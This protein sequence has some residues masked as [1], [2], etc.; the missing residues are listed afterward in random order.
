MCSYLDQVGSTDYFRRTVPKDLVGT[1]LTNSGRARTEW[2]DSLATKDRETA[3]R[4]L[5][6]HEIDTDALID[7]ARADAKSS[8]RSFPIGEAAQARGLELEAA[9]LELAEE[10]RVRHEG[11]SPQRTRWR[12]RRHIS[13]AMAVPAVPAVPAILGDSRNR[14][15]GA[16]PLWRDFPQLTAR[17]F[18]GAFPARC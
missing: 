15:P 8:H 11:R 6:P 12:K 9:R 13:T 14:T 16:G 17:R 2:K 7:N 18:A 1:F 10:S 3:K 4:R 5:R